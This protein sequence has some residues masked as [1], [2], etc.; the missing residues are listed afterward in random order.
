ML[1]CKIKNPITVKLLIAE[2]GNS[3]KEFSKKVNV[4]HTY[5]SQVINGKRNPS[6]L[7]ASKIANGLNT[8]V[9]DLFIIKTLNGR[10]VT[11]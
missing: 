11:Q 2:T 7:V 5:L 8:K 4:S 1:S 9:E 6:L 10:N 3:Q